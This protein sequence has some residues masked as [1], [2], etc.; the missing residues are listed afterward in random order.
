MLKIKRIYDEW[1]KEDGFR[2]L[3][4]RL[5]PRGVSKEEAKLEQWF[6]EIAPSDKLRKDF[7]HEDEEFEDFKKEYLQELKEND[8]K[9]EFLT[10]IKEKLDLGNVTLLYA[11]KNETMNNAVV[12]K[13][14]IQKNL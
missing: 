14:W 1:R 2:V 6:K 8:K 9:E 7:H 12:L 10:L 5:W 11:A 3:V 4:D 13:E